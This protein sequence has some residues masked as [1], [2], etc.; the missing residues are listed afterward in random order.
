MQSVT[1]MLIHY[2]CRVHKLIANYSYHYTK[3]HNQNL[4]I[5]FKLTSSHNVSKLEIL[6]Y[7]GKWHSCELSN[8]ERCR[9]RV[10]GGAGG[11]GETK[12]CLV[13]L[14]AGVREEVQL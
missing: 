9:C 6:Y 11:G 10:G 4:C 5:T 3:H 14:V 1:Y 12:L 8:D 7:G 13:G 2:T